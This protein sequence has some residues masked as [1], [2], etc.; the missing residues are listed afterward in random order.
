MKKLQHIVLI[1][2]IIGFFRSNACDCPPTPK[3]DEAY[4]ENYTLIF[5]GSVVSVGECKELSKAHFKI[6][7]LFKGKSP[8][9][10]DVLFDCSGPCAMNFNPGETW[11]I[12]AGFAQVGKPS[13]SICS[14]SR[15]QID[16]EIEVKTTFIP[17]DLSF[18]EEIE[19]LAKNLG[20]QALLETNN[21][22]DLSHKNTLP[23]PKQS[24]ILVI[25]SFAGLLLI[26][27]IIKKL[28]K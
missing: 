14:R 5:R 4:T 27:F 15:K 21:N 23:D 2:L 25:A 19:W 20:R 1:V 3:L 18:N 12:Y 11:L 7:D 6:L 13:L 26:Y 10:I 9:E 8:K 16:N 17:T 24:I 22:A 28:I